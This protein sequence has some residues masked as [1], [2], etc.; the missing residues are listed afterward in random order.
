MQKGFSLVELSIVL[1]ILGLLVG[2]I[3][4]GQNLVRAAELRSIT[5][6]RDQYVAAIQIFRDK[7]LALPGDM[8]NAKAFWGEAAAGT[9]CKTTIGTGTQTCNGNG[10][11]E[12][13]YNAT[14]SN[15]YFRSIQHLAN[16]GLINGNYTGIGGTDGSDID[17]AIIGTNTPRAKLG[18]AGWTLRTYGDYGGDVE[19][20]NS[21]FLSG[22]DYGHI[23]DFGSQ[24]GGNTT[25]G[26]ILSP[27][28]V[29]N[30][31]T[32]IDD[33]R[34]GHGSVILRHIDFCATPSGNTDVNADYLLSETGKLCAIIFRNVI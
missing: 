12:I 28:E 21:A 5:T 7:Y 1:V 34:P 17:H 27:E 33:G 22:G 2:G 8:T 15:E 9:A 6:E 18:N 26:P 20:Y 11:G 24:T 19:T 10:N 31:D 30:I 13:H 25:R 32:K 16:A 14:E 29:W 4:T 3:L 23:L